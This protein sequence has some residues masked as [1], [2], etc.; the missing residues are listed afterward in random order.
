MSV[1]VRV[2]FAGDSEKMSFVFGLMYL[3]MV[4]TSVKSTKSNCIPMSVNIVRHTRFVPPY[5]QF[6]MTQ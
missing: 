5:E 3:A 6:V 1:N 4:A 2:G